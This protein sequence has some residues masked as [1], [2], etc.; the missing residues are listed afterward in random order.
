MG[1]QPAAEGINW[2]GTLGVASSA[3]STGVDIYSSIMA[4]KTSAIL[5]EQKA[6]TEI[7]NDNM[8]DIVAD[9]DKSIIDTQY[10]QQNADLSEIFNQSDVTKQT[11]S[12]MQNRTVDSLSST[13]EADKRQYQDEKDMSLLNKDMAKTAINNTRQNESNVARMNADQFKAEGKIAKDASYVDSF[14]KLMKGTSDLVKQDA[15]S[16]KKYYN[17]GT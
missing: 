8:K 2:G 9:I 1:T 17:E 11:G 15:F 13:T 6:K 10:A 12:M 14:S 7:F 16:K 3:I 4:G 5:A